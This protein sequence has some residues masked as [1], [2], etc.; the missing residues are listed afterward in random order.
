[1]ARS[2]SNVKKFLKENE[3]S[4]LETK[5]EYLSLWNTSK[6]N[7]RFNYICPEGHKTQT[8]LA[9]FNNTKS[10]LRRGTRKKLCSTCNGGRGV[11]H[12][13]SFDF[14]AKEILE[15][16]GHQLIK[17]GENRKCVYTCGRCGEK[18]ESFMSNLEKSTG[19]CKHC[20]NLIMAKTD[21]ENCCCGKQNC[22]DCKMKKYKLEVEKQGMELL[23]TKETYISSHKLHVRCVCGTEKYSTFGDIKRGKKCV[24]CKT[25][26]YKATCL[27]KYGCKNA[28]QNEEIKQKIRETNQKNLGVDYPQ[29]NKEVK[30]KTNK[31]CKEKY[32]Y[33]YAFNKPE[34][35]ERIRE[36]HIKNH[37]VPF[38]LQSKKIQEKGEQTCLKNY[39]VPKHL[40]TY[41][42]KDFVMPS[43]KII[44]IQ[45]NEDI[46]IKS[47]LSQTHSIFKRPLYEEEIFV[48][49]EVQNFNYT[50]R[51]GKQR[52]YYP[53]IFIQ[54]SF[55][56][57]KQI[58][59][60]LIISHLKDFSFYIEVKSTWTFNREPE[61]NFEKF[62]AVAM[63]GNLL[64]VYIYDA[65]KLWDVWTFLPFMKKTPRSM[66]KKVINFDEP[67]RLRKGE[68]SQE[69]REYIAVEEFFG[70]LEI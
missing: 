20:A 32:G 42:S 58:D 70:Q 29:Q 28:F 12:D 7:F 18:S 47:L 46:A 11:K 56:V 1:M 55:R 64:K 33:D 26:K 35:Y 25:E 67:I 30:A 63:A 51:Q 69:D 19:K 45:G 66:S 17:I 38:P 68:L 57:Y 22:L 10:E 52:K 61:T 9:I 31:T 65:K 23:T 50:D 44:Q 16:N 13:Y 27:E 62:K 2:Y 21:S 54:G 14:H 4:V 36:T 40:L 8:S 60:N 48:G 15:K 24:K 39:G 34:V 41:K 59:E 5:K 37:G 49:P 3:Y 43:G 53:D 6:R